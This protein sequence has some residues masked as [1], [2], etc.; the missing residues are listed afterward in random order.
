MKKNNRSAKE[1]SKLYDL[2]MKLMMGSAAAVVVVVVLATPIN[3]P[4]VDILNVFARGNEVVYEIEIKGTSNI[5]ESLVISLNAVYESYEKKGVIGYQSDSFSDLTVGRTYTLSVKANW[6]F[7][8][9]TLKEQRITLTKD[10]QVKLNDL[11]QSGYN[12]NF[13]FEVFDSF[14]RITD[15]KVSVQLVLGY[16][17]IYLNDFDLLETNYIYST[18]SNIKVNQ[19]YQFRI[20]ANTTNGR[21]TLLNKTI[22]TGDKPL[23][24]LEA[25]AESETIMYYAMVDDFNNT[26]FSNEIEVH[27]Y[28]ENN[29]LE[30]VTHTLDSQSING[31]FDTVV[32][33][34]Y[35]QV[36]VVG[37]LFSGSIVLFETIV[38]K[39]PN[40]YLDNLILEGNTLS[41]SVIY[42]APYLIEEYNYV[43]SIT[44]STTTKTLTII[45]NPNFVFN[46]V[47]DEFVTV[48]L[49]LVLFNNEIHHQEQYL[50][51]QTV[52][53]ISPTTLE[54]TQQGTYMINYEVVPIA[55]QL[56]VI[57]NSE[58]FIIHLSLS[59]QTSY[60]GYIEGLGA[61][62]NLIELYSDYGE[63]FILEKGTQIF[64]N[65]VILFSEILPSENG[66]ILYLNYGYHT[67][68]NYP[69]YLK[70][71]ETSI[72]AETTLELTTVDPVLL[73]LIDGNYQFEIYTMYDNQVILLDVTS[74]TLGD[75]I[76][77]IVFDFT[78][79]EFSY[80]SLSLEA[81]VNKSYSAFFFK[82]TL[83]FDQQTE[84]QFYT[85]DL[86]MLPMINIPIEG[87]FDTLYVQ[88]IGV[89]NGVE[90]IFDES[91]LIDDRV[92]AYPYMYTDMGDLNITYDVIDKQGLTSTY[93]L[94]IF[95]E[96]I[97]VLSYNYERDSLLVLDDLSES[98]YRFDLLTVL[99]GQPE[100]ISSQYFDVYYDTYFKVDGYQ[101]SLDETN[102][103]I[104]FD[105]FL[106]YINKT[107]LTD[108]LYVNISINYGGQYEQYYH[109]TLDA[110]SIRLEYYTDM[111]FIGFYFEITHGELE[112]S[113]IV[114]SQTILRNG[115]VISVDPF[116]D[117]QTFETS[118]LFNYDNTNTNLISN[119]LS[120]DVIIISS[121]FYTS[122]TI[123][124]F[125]LEN[126]VTSL[127]LENI[128]PN[129]II[130]VVV[131]GQ[132]AFGPEILYAREIY[133]P[134]GL[135]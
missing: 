113:P 131:T 68:S 129:D 128:Q 133:I 28:R 36:K 92:L 2:I 132:M 98:V 59:N 77:I 13:S 123:L 60:S 41:G 84:T 122:G 125:S 116:F 95:L 12:I 63:G 52:S 106:D 8:L 82:F 69:L 29:L 83:E 70:Y 39:A 54:V 96:D 85:F 11:S 101:T 7:G 4:N 26:L 62:L 35:Y 104:Y 18:I 10:P 51:Y 126:N 93:T 3:K 61:G 40:A 50:D 38:F 105:F 88:V 114:F 76:S 46:E 42:E 16:N 65:P 94:E 27:L 75:T 73:N 100:V 87:T 32:A 81:N 37:K 23:G 71:Y 66:L 45:D 55:S 17:Q 121:S 57:Q 33:Q 72:L 25:Y 115:P 56:K 102:T 135:A 89:L 19:T 53:A 58:S 24:Y 130:Q 47:F 86:S 21:K 9:G 30:K 78:E 79:G 107:Y 99:N 20:L 119:T 43:V 127:L 31:A 80:I 117:Q 120:I 108:P 48:Q 124:N 49:Y 109:Q 90:V 22:K 6:G 91:S 118:L 112:N 103:L 1:R 67:P 111:T 34:G 5:E 44:G 110:T 97:L 14:S 64:I 74:Y 15:G 134:G